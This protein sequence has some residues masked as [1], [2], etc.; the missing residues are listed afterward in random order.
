MLHEKKVQEWQANIYNYPKLRIYVLFKNSFVD[1]PYVTINMNRKYRSALAR[2]RGGI[3]PLEIEVGRWNNVDIYARF[4]K[5]CNNGLIENEY[6]FMFECT[7]CLLALSNVDVFIVMF[8]ELC[9]MY[10]S[11]IN[12]D[13][14]CIHTYIK[15]CLKHCTL[16]IFVQLID[17]SWYIKIF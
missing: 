6:H 4:C 9:L 8:I 14:T 12:K 5:L 13:I 10:I 7:W 16:V 2:L 1:E 11:Y 15:A 17:T 3:L